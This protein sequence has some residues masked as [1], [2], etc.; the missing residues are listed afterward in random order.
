MAKEK[1]TYIRSFGGIDIKT[2]TKLTQ[3]VEEQLQRGVDRFVLLM[4]SP[5]D[6]VFAG[7]TGFS[8]LK[9]IPAEVV[10]HNCRRLSSEQALQY[11]LAHEIRSDLYEK[12]SRVLELA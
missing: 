12:G 1:T 7:L 6:G 8:Y 10:T 3:L 4:S 11:G 2:I 5:G 9:G